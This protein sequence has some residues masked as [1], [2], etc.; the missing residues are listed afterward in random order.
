MRNFLIKNFVLDYIYKVWGVTFRYTRGAVII[1]PTFVITG[2]N[3]ALDLDWPEID[4]FDVLSLVW[5]LIT[6]FFGFAYFRMKPVKFDELKDLEQVFVYEQ[7]LNK[8]IIFQELSEEMM[9]K[10]QEANRYVRDNI[11]NKRNY[12]P[13]RILMHP[14]VAI[15][16]T[17]IIAVGY[18]Y[19]TGNI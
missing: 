14:L 3:I 17:T 13:H 4:L 11:E 19:L 15:I 5:L 18:T 1:W 2:L 16:I 7:A 6:V 10:M 9:F 8:K 12:K